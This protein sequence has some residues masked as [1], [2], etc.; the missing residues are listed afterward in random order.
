MARIEVGQILKTNYGTGPYRV[1]SIVR[2]CVDCHD[3]LDF[4]DEGAKLPA[5][6]HMTLRSIGKDHN[7]GSVA[8]LNYYDEETLRNVRKND[9]DR[10]IL[11]ANLEPVQTTLAL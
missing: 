3:P 7:E 1:E 10:L 4:F 2:N 9:R 8:Y 11:L 6:I 5:H